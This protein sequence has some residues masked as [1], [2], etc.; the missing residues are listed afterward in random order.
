MA[1]AQVPECSADELLT[2]VS[3][4]RPV[5]RREEEAIAR[6]RTELARLERPCDELADPV[7][8]TAS[9]I[10][11]GR[12]GTVMHRHRRL[13]RWMQPGGHIDPGETP[14]AAAL[15]E[16]TEE[17]GLAMQFD[18]RGPRVV[19]VDVHEAANGHTHLDLRFLLVGADDDPAPPPGES[20]DV[21]W[22]SWEEAEEM[23]DDA[24]AG[25]LR[26]ARRAWE[27]LAAGGEAGA[28]GAAR[29]RA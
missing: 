3:S 22:C 11:V 23:A 15:R 28:Q 26:S 19:H 27:D 21:R 29:E 10:V 4:H 25:G 12:R 6:F 9:G 17:T 24:L 5:D 14:P 8:V 13:G 1:P 7:H 20:P 2:L 18:P 16:C